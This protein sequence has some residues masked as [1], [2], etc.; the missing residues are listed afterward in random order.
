[1]ENKPHHTG[2]PDSHPPPANKDK[3]GVDKKPGEEQGK[4]EQVTDEDL[5][6]KKVDRDITKPE[7]EPLDR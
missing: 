1:M 5:K 7:D 6:G 3:Q 4:Q 2:Q